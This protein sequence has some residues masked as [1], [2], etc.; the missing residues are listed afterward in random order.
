MKATTE[1]NYKQRVLQA[2]IFIQNNLN[3]SLSLDEIAQ[4]SYLSRFHFHRIFTAM[5]GESVQAY[6]R[7]LRLERAIFILQHEKC[8][9]LDIALQAGYQSNEA[10]SR[11]IKKRYGLSPQAIRHLN[12]FS[13]QTYQTINQA[14]LEN[15]SM[16]VD[17][18]T[19]EAIDV[20]F[21][22]HIGSYRKADVAWTKIMKWAQHND[23]FAN[24]PDT[25]RIGIAHDD[26]AITAEEKLRYDACLSITCDTPNNIGLHYQTIAGGKYAVAEHK[27]AYD[28]FP[29]AFTWLFGD[30]LPNS[31]QE[32]RDEPCF[33]IYK[34]SIMNT[35]TEELRSDIYI[36]LK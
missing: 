9:I 14:T 28:K 24:N 12:D 4:A 3:E 7:R 33:V 31:H 23:F 1:N 29:V 2:Q 10:F 26:P 22:R 17:I 13:P 36:P 30:W 19:T 5:S 6:I 34:N 8:S 25:L 32:V 21:T 15:Y 16:N 27:G 18:K 20:I 35:P 11:V